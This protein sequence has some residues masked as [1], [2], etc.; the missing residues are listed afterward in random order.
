MPVDNAVE[1]IYSDLIKGAA[2]TAHS[3]M[4]PLTGAEGDVRD[5][6]I[7][8]ALTEHGFHHRGQAPHIMSGA[9]GNLYQ[10]PED[11]H[12]FVHTTEG[13][14]WSSFHTTGLV[15]RLK[16]E[17]TGSTALR[18]HL[19][20]ATHD[21]S[22]EH[23]KKS[24]TMTMVIWKA[25]GPKPGD[26]S[27]GMHHVHLRGG[28]SQHSQWSY[29]A[30]N[31]QGGS[32]GTNVGAGRPQR[33]AHQ[34]AVHAIPHGTRY[35]LSINEK[36][37]GVHTR[38]QEKWATQKA[39]D[40]GDV[41]KAGSDWKAD[42]A[43]RGKVSGVAA[44]HGYKPTIRKDQGQVS[45]H[46]YEH[47][48][49]GRRIEH[50][51]GTNLSGHTYDHWTHLHPVAGKPK[52]NWTHAG[53]GEGAESLHAHLS[54]QKSEQPGDL[55]K[56]AQPYR[57]LNC[58]HE[59]WN[60]GGKK[61]HEAETGHQKGWTDKPA[62]TAGRDNMRGKGPDQAKSRSVERRMVILK[63]ASS[64]KMRETAKGH[65]WNATR[66]ISGGMAFSHPAHEGH[67]L[68][69][70]EKGTWKHHAKAESPDVSQTLDSG[71]GHVSLKRHLIEF[72]GIKKA[73]PFAHDPE[74]GTRDATVHQGH[75]CPHCSA[76]FPKAGQLSTH[77][78]AAHPGKPLSGAIQK[79]GMKR[80]LGYSD[81][82]HDGRRVT[83]MA[84]NTGTTHPFKEASKGIKC[85]DC[86]KGEG[87]VFHRPPNP[88]TDWGVK[89]EE[90]GDIQKGEGYHGVADQHGYKRIKEGHWQHSSG[91]TIKVNAQGGWGHYRDNDKGVGVGILAMGS[92]PETLHRHLRGE[93]ITSA[94]A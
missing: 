17:G 52:G 26:A 56:S 73:D 69:V 79:G 19:S 50:T 72:H 30:H 39:E 53:H 29:T 43:K 85:A 64:G 42:A 3:G 48:E 13:G 40:A 28:P 57:C 70:H 4:I 41:E 60:L 62:V 63:S 35:H 1:S 12:H 32:F 24:E 87:H 21:Y 34:E 2:T 86:G 47:P 66:P 80:M 7:H 51:V 77:I 91:K 94:G 90:S 65:G 89:S 20:G 9:K 88:K 81:N 23:P 36:Y 18:L 49:S 5:Q 16:H 75:D 11:K 74:K 46:H 61:R 59:T 84:G 67:A 22:P 83:D 6:H 44:Q 71:E 45:T 8:Q 27:D 25:E 93:N 14:R 15:S 92:R 38:G 54:G 37:H 58:G 78:E 68:H 55:E 33:A 76:K 82:Y 10:H 31:P